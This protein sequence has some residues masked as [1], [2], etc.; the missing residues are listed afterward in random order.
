MKHP[1]LQYS[2][3]LPTGRMKVQLDLEPEADAVLIADVVRESA[4]AR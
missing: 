4:R 1:S 2:A 3:R